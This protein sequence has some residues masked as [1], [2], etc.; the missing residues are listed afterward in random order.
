MSEE[1]LIVDGVAARFPRKL[2]LIVV[3]VPPVPLISVPVLLRYR[4]VCSVPVLVNTP[5]LV[6]PAK[7][8]VN[9]PVLVNVPVLVRLPIKAVRL[10]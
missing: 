5:A 6:S 2:P 10:P 8:P 9:E 1:G 3:S 7:A 4:V